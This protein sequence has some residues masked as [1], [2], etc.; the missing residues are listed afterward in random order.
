MATF[1]LQKPVNQQGVEKLLNFFAALSPRQQTFVFLAAIIFV[2]AQKKDFE[3]C[4]AAIKE[5]RFQDD[6]GD[7]SST[8]TL[9]NS[10]G[11]LQNLNLL[12]WKLQCNPQIIE[13]ISRKA[14]LAGCHREFADIVRRELPAEKGQGNKSG[15]FLRDARIGLYNNDFDLFNRSLFKY[16]QCPEIGETAA[17]L[18]VIFNNPFDSQ[19]FSTLPPYLQL[20]GL[21]EIFQESL[22]NLTPCEGPLNFLLARE[23]EGDIPEGGES[24]FYYLLISQLILRGRIPASTALLARIGENILG[25][26]LRGWLEFLKG[27]NSR[28]LEFFNNDLASLK[29]IHGKKDVFFTGP[30]GLFF[31]LA[32]LNSG[33]YSFNREIKNRVFDLNR[34]QPNSIFL[35]ACN[36]LAEVAEFQT[37]FSATNYCNCWQPNGKNSI[38]A[39]FQGMAH[40]WINGYLETEQKEEIAVLCKQ[41][42]EAGYD[43]LAR[44]Y[45]ELLSRSGHKNDYHEF[46]RSFQE[47]NRIPSII[48]ACRQ[49]ERW[50]RALKALNAVA[51][52]VG[53]RNR[54]SSRLAWMVQ[55]DHDFVTI[56]PR[57]QKLGSRGRWSHGR[58]VALQ[59]IYSGEKLD[60]LSRHDQKI[61]ATLKKNKTRSGTSYDF[62]MTETLPALIGHPNLFLAEAPAVAVE[63]IQGEPELRIKEM[64][65]ELH[66]ELYPDLMTDKVTAVRE[67]PTR[68]AVMNLSGEHRKIA[69]IIGEEGLLVP[70]AAQKEVLHTIG[71]LA[72]CITV[73]SAIGGVAKDT[74]TVVADARIIIHL[75]PMGAGFRLT[76]LVRPFTS[77]GP[78]V[79]PGQGSENIIAEIGGERFQARRNLVQEIGN[80]KKI[81]TACPT[82]AMLDNSEWE[83]EIGR[84]E[85][86]LQLLLELEAIKEQ[87][88]IEWPEG[89]KISLA[90]KVSFEQFHL[91]IRKKNNW[92][93][94]QG[95]LRLDE[96]KVI[97]MQSLLALVRTNPGK[98]IPLDDQ[99][100][101]VLSN[102][103]RKQL[104]EL[105]IFT[106]ERGG[107]I[108]LHPLAALSLAELDQ[109]KCNLETDK[110]WQEIVGRL[111]ECREL[112]PDVPSTL[113]AELRTYQLE[114]FRWLAGLAHMG[115]GACLAD[116]MGLGKTLQGLAIILDKASQGPSLVVAPTSVCLNWQEEIKRF[117]PT[118]NNIIFGGRQREK[119]LL[120]LQPFDVVVSS[121][122]LL[123]QE[124]ELLNKINWQV[125]VLDEAQA[126]KNITTKRSKAAMSLQGEFKLITTGTP[127]ENH[128]GELWNLFHFINPGL[129]GTLEQ[130]NKKYAQPIERQQN[131][132]VQRR[133]KK[134]IQPF[135][136][137]RLKSLVLDELPPRTEVLLQVEMSDDE[138]AFYEM[139]RRN[140]VE[141][142]SESNGAPG[143]RH[144][145]IL[146]EIM[147]LR[148]ACCHCRLVV[149]ESD[150]PS[151]KLAVFAK[152]TDELLEN[153]H[154]ALVFSQFV[155]HLS[156]IR[157]RLD[158]KKI[159]YCYLDGNTST[160]VRQQQ[161][162]AFQKGV[163]D[164]FL[165]SLKAGG[166]G[167]NLTA[168]DYVIHMDPWWNPAVEDQA[169]DRAH[170][171]GQKRPVTI[172]RLV[173]RNSIEEKIVKLHRAKRALADSLLDS[174]DMGPKL[175][176][177]EL[178]RLIR[179]R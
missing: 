124:I 148:R 131:R 56:I 145:Q 132:K 103:F 104:E 147:K 35:P 112:R 37:T 134:L 162:S 174:T 136:L 114:G 12:N 93:E 101:I 8:E 85:E 74:K 2:P 105:N 81:E 57:E 154:R 119:Q 40:F 19:W 121:Y 66:I 6:E 9:N 63:F 100:F 91:K 110:H 78:Y 64:D 179:E 84:T 137:R 116:D 83:W 76:M 86:C 49:E 14:V 118:L 45:A 58:P 59:R 33:D 129:L 159:T 140:A 150:I 157:E 117:A 96:D 106:E 133:L 135:I 36:V 166:V 44:E 29:K 75:L 22:V 77:D 41:A 164:L 20:H 125:I 23:K 10:L 13:I 113:Q 163:G 94:L 90:Q 73:H 155:D 130:F 122:G 142:I 27:K 99:Q 171:L 139:L 53:E 15:H 34:N 69:A 115:A 108:H 178:L 28:A 167:L 80:C 82:L 102:R 67:T 60:F 11:R 17:P 128:L 165:I 149:P 42:M 30:E 1:D 46:C 152:I 68:F 71:K 109:E 4:L 143:S 160:K 127:I 72:S 24:S 50:Q 25:F 144:L 95:N 31:M 169:S 126:I 107:K 54:R 175:N 158:E 111:Q 97:D 153:R 47:R 26:G 177:E 88:T 38:S 21:R 123:Q 168:A 18:A 52:P 70:A 98:F 173:T 87:V 141:K 62:N 172:Y 5:V 170:R 3:R 48:T 79:R 156:I 120:S 39:L 89:Q 65:N 43:W 92:F 51:S 7:D 32:L 55:F 146:A 16:Y 151:S 138:M 161:I 176:A 61:R